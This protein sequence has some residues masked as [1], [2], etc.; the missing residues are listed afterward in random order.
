MIVFAACVLECVLSHTLSFKSTRA[1]CAKTKS[2]FLRPFVFQV[3]KPAAFYED[4]LESETADVPP[5]LTH[6]LGNDDDRA[7]LGM[8]MG[9]TADTPTVHGD[10]GGGGGGGD[11]GGGGSGDGGGGG[12]TASNTSRSPACSAPQAVPVGPSIARVP[13]TSASMS[14][15]AVLPEDVARD[16]RAMPLG[17]VDEDEQQ[18]DL[19]EVNSWQLGL[20]DISTAECVT[21]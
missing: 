4:L 5:A 11:G 10:G 13:A 1:R 16:T 2:P 20:G 17:A 6:V 8:L 3:R 18:I 19:R 9:Q 12:T 14:Q 15:I 21:P 7:A